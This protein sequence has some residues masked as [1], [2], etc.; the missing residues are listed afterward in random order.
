MNSAQPV[1]IGMT[2]LL[3]IAR[4]SSQ[5]DSYYLQRRLQEEVKERKKLH[6]ALL[7][8][9]GAIRVFCRVRPL[10]SDAEDIIVEC[11]SSEASVNIT[12]GRS[13]LRHDCF[14]I[15]M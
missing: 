4:C 11:D 8:L 12:T 2:L 6:N 3:Q 14:C 1:E 10:L 5:A 15:S 9:K 7:D 13:E